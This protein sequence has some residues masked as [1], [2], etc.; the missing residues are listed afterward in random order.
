MCDCVKG[1]NTAYSPRTVYSIVPATATHGSNVVYHQNASAMSDSVVRGD[2]SAFYYSPP[3]MQMTPHQMTAAASSCAVPGI[4][5]HGPPHM[6]LYSATGA[7][8]QQEPSLQPRDGSA[9]GKTDGGRT[10]RSQPGVQ[11][12]MPPAQ[13]H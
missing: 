13:R 5:V 12:Y 11:L 2:A 6:Q 8:P 1:V 3:Y 7:H 9:R 10:G 4:L